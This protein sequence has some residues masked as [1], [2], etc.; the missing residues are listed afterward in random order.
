MD[1]CRL[2]SESVTKMKYLINVLMP[3]GELRTDIFFNTM[4]DVDQYVRELRED[5]VPFK[6]VVVYDNE[7]REAIRIYKR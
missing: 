5:D 6:R 1:W 7:T 3:G 4:D 2:F